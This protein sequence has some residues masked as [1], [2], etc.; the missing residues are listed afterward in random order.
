MAFAGTATVLASCTS[1]STTPQIGLNSSAT[2]E[3]FSEAAYGVKASPR[4]I[5]DRAHRMPHGGGHELVGDPYKVK[6]KWYRPHHRFQ[7]QQ[8]R[9]GLL[10]RRTPSMAG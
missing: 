4:V 1:S 5:S 7:L 6:G 8:G 10:V 2:N 3:Y 9:H